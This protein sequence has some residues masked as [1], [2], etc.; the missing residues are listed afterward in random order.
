MDQEAFHQFFKERYQ[1]ELGQARVRALHY[2]WWSKK[3]DLVLII[4]SATTTILLAIA[5]FFKELPITPITAILSAFVT[6]IA[7]GM[8]TLKTQEKWS[9]YQTLYND[10]NNE[11]YDYKAQISNYQ[12]ALD[13]EALFVDRVRAL[14]GEADKKMPL[15]TLPDMSPMS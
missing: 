6:V 8:T 1:V 12:E 4:L 5:S 7:T 2:Q 15:R 14:L 11:Y 9:F 10:L 3:L 13:K